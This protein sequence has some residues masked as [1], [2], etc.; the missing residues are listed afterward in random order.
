MKRCLLQDSAPGV[1]AFTESRFPKSDS[2]RPLIKVRA[3]KNICEEALS[4]S[5]DTF[6]APTHLMN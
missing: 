1:S 2:D 3:P 4:T 6:A 5:L